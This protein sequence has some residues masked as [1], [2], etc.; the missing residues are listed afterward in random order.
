MIDLDE[1]VKVGDH[2][3]ASIKDLKARI[4][5]RPIDFNTLLPTDINSDVYDLSKA[6]AFNDQEKHIAETNLGTRDRNNTTAILGIASK[7]AST[8]AKSAVLN[9][10]NCGNAIHIVNGTM[11]KDLKQD[12]DRDIFALTASCAIIANALAEKGDDLDRDYSDKQG[13]GVS[14]E[15]MEANQNNSYQLPKVSKDSLMNE[16]YSYIMS[17]K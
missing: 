9:K 4:D 13:A 1:E 5:K 11:G 12:D 7:L 8:F 3:I 14:K 2:V 17:S 10:L 15:D 6:D 16:I